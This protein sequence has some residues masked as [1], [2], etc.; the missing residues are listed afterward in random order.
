[1]Y[2]VGSVFRVLE[3]SL[4]NLRFPRDARVVDKVRVSVGGH[5]GSMFNEDADLAKF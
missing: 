1:M 2:V 4:V 3:A 5:C